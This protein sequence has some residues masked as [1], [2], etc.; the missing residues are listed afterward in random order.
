M[1]NYSTIKAAFLPKIG[2]RQNVDPNKTQLVDLTTSTSGL[3]YNDAHPLLTPR[4]LEALAFDDSQVTYSSYGVGTEYSF[5]EVVESSGTNYIYINQ[6]PST[7]NTPPNSTYW[8]E[9]ESLTETLRQE[10]EAGIVKCVSDWFNKK[11]KL[12]TANNLLSNEYMV[13]TT[14]DISD[15]TANSGKTR[16]IEITPPQS[17]N[18]KFEPYKIGLQFTVA[19][20]IPIKI[21]KSGQSAPIHTETF[22]YTNANSMQWFDLDVEFEGGFR[23]WI[24]YNESDITGDS[25]NGLVDRGYYQDYITFPV[26]KFYDAV[27]GYHSNDNDA[28]WDLTENTYNVVNNY[29]MNFKVRVQC[30]YTQFIIDQ[31]DEFLIPMQLSVAMYVLRKLALNPEANVNRRENKIDTAQILY[32]IDG[33]SRG[34]SLVNRSMK[35]Q[36]EEALNSIA[37]DNSGVDEVCLPCRRRGV[38]YSGI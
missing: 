17:L 3:Y 18:L 19:E 14:G 1:I 21:F 7:G 12:Q 25:I 28:L 33:D 15:T 20:N 35:V 9:Y 38:K 30:D 2:W 11:S 23:Y 34:N 10:T 31:A 27:G 37:F 4:V 26:G 16:F 8:R 36:Y 6:T 13:K 24:T 22:A 32:E 29:G 5:G